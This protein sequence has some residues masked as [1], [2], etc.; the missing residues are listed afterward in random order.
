VKDSFLQ[1]IGVQCDAPPPSDLHHV[2]WMARVQMGAVG[3][4]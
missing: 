4:W 2:G 1:V 3:L